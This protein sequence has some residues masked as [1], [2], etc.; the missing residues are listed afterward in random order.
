MDP[1]P[2]NEWLR[3]AQEVLLLAGSCFLDDGGG[4]GPRHLD[5]CTVHGSTHWR[6]H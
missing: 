2:S 4:I 1:A 3:E 6:S 5:S